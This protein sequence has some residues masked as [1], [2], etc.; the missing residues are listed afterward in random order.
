LT[1]YKLPTNIKLYSKKEIMF[2]N[3]LITQKY[4]CVYDQN[5]YTAFIKDGKLF[6]KQYPGKSGYYLID[7]K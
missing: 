1:D 7:Y 2:N 5:Y 6:A 4:Y 3:D